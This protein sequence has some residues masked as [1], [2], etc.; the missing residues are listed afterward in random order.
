MEKSF[1]EWMIFLLMQYRDYFI[2]GTITTLIL[3]SVGTFLGFLVGFIMGLI[4]SIEIDSI[5]NK[6]LKVVCEALIIISKVY[7]T[8]FRGTPMIVQAMVVYYGSSQVFGLDM[9]PALAA[10]IVIT[11]NTGAYMAETVRGGILSVDYGQIE[12]AKALGMKHSTTMIS[13]IL[14]QALRNITPQMGNTFVANI[15]DISVLN[16]ISVTELFFT[17]KTAA[18][19]YYRYFEAYM[20]TAAIYLVLTIIANQILKLI[21]KV[22]KGNENYKLVNEDELNIGGEK[23]E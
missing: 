23:Y 20:I 8:V 4:D 15:K 14:P 16:V 1:L 7:V 17:T 19:T 2:S 11:F 22:Q 13:V 5:K 12:G 6:A 21:E 3:A 18:S 9:S 10:I